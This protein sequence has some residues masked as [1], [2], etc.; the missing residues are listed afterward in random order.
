MGKKGKRVKYTA[1]TADKYELYQFS[2]QSP[3]EDIRFLAR[4]FKKSRGTAARHFR[5]DFCGTSLLTATWVKRGRDYT[6]E[7]FDIDP[8]P[9]AWGRKRNLDP[10]GKAASRA[11]LHQ[12]D[13]RHP[14][15]R[16]PDVRCAQNFSYCVFKTRSELLEYFR[17]AH[18]DLARDGI[19]VL[20]VHGGPECLEEMEEETEQEEGFTYVW[21]Q[22][23]YWPVTGETMSYIHFRFADGSEMKR[24]FRYDWRLWHL[25]ELKE[26]LMDAGFASVDCYWEG[27]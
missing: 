8:E 18:D 23:E 6:A 21:D 1:K 4:V 13:V 9:L 7:G 5:E 12:A 14:S 25:P 3:V 11:T 26:A 16:P 22:D 20:D 19:F 24:A 10:L 2:V 27:T 15:D 17:A